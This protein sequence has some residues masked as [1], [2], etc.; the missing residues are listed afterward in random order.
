[1]ASHC[2]TWSNLDTANE[3]YPDYTQYQL[4]YS[5]TT[6]SAGLTNPG[7]STWQSGVFSAGST[8]TGTYTL[9]ALFFTE[10]EFTINSTLY[11]QKGVTYC[12]RITNAGS[13]TNFVYITQPQLTIRRNERPEGGGGGGPPVGGGTLGGRTPCYFEAK[14]C[15][16]GRRTI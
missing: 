6:D 12:F 16:G 7:G 3:W 4:G 13:I 9:P 1:M 8:T 10:H 14:P 15:G 5:S 11:T 2:A